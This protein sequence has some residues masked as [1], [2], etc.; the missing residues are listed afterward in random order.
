MNIAVLE[1][2]EMTDG[3]EQRL[4]KLGRVQI[5]DSLT[6]KQCIE[7]VR[8]A[9]VVVID[10]IDPKGF[11][12]Y[13]KSNSLL[14]LM[15]TGYSWID[16][17]GARS[18]G[19][20]IANIPTYATEAVAEH[21]WGLVL[22][23]LRKIAVGTRIVR[24]GGWEQGQIR[25][26]E[27]KNSI[28]GV[29]GLGRIGRRMAEIGQ[30][31]FDMKVITHNRTP[32]NLPNIKEVGL[33]ELLKEADVISINCDLNSTSR[34]LVGEKEY[35]F[36]KP[37]VVIVSATWDVINLSALIAALK[38]N[39]ILG[40]GLDIA[41]EGGEPELPKELLRLDNVVLTPHVAYNTKES[42][43]R[44]VNMCIDNIESFTKGKPR[45]IV[46]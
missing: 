32:K 1:R 40:A 10:W 41:A 43:I 26:L 20:S 39:R 45:N 2:I 11:L 37:T 21:L 4:G 12:K 18:L 9:D 42:K 28:L 8:N 19:I 23:V 13:M 5:Y 17:E 6:Q 7:R 29:I 15:S 38:N 27:L 16:I 25:G 31:A 22:I 30:R 33:Q 35:D 34:D 44:Q 3:Q 46:N 24:E 14:A 36:V